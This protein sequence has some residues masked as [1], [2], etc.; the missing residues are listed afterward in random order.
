[1]E[2]LP[3]DNRPYLWWRFGRRDKTNIFRAVDRSINT[4]IA[5]EQPSITEATIAKALILCA[6]EVS[7]EVFPRYCL[8]DIKS[9]RS[10]IQALCENTSASILHYGRISQIVHLKGGLSNLGIGGFLGKALQSCN[11]NHIFKQNC[12]NVGYV[13]N[14][15]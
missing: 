7:V 15:L 6:D 2:S 9:N 14:D 5:Q 11:L 13:I 1:M 3:A 10:I 4:D 12:K 8:W